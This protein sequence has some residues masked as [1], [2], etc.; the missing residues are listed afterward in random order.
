MRHVYPSAYLTTA[1]VLPM[2]SGEI[3]V[4]YY[5]TLLTAAHAQQYAFGG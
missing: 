5:N 2:L 3:A 1:T 4:Q